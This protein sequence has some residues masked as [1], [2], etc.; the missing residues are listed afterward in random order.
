MAEAVGFCRGV[1]DFFEKQEGEVGELEW[2]FTTDRPIYAQIVEQIQRGILSGAYPPGSNMPSVR[3]LALEAEVNPNTM[4]KALAELES[5]GLL[6]TQ[7]TSGR[8]VTADER[9]I[10]GLKQRAEQELVEQ[11]FTGMQKLG[12]ERSEAIS[13]L[14]TS[15]NQSAVL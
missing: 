11:Y 15:G 7:R 9:L 1:Q 3:A 8:T 13:L 14:A 2:R 12:V 10:A 4:Q 6:S 5:Q